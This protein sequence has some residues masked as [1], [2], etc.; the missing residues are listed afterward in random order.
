MPKNYVNFQKLSKKLGDRSRS[1]IHRY[2]RDRGFPKP[3]QIGP[4]SVIWDEDAVDAWIE[5]QAMAGYS[6]KVVAPG[7]KRGRARKVSLNSSITVG[8]TAEEV[9]NEIN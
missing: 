3:I 2:M 7:S 1:T 6:P 4:N 8:N 9:C 5:Q